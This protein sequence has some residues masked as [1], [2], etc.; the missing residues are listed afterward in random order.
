M[1]K[2]G[3]RI[4]QIRENSVP[5]ITR[6]A[7]AKEIGVSAEALRRIE[8]GKTKSPGA[9]LLDNLAKALGISITYLLHGQEQPDLEA[10]QL[11]LNQITNS[12][13]QINLPYALALNNRERECLARR[14]E[15]EFDIL[16]EQATLKEM[17]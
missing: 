16:R 12:T 6:E 14:L 8:T 5:P 4:R 15:V 13:L 17:S 2:L 3:N 7:L 10:D 11:M 1:S 9:Y